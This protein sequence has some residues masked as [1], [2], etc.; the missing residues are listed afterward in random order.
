MDLIHLRY[1]HSVFLKVRQALLDQQA[2]LALLDRQDP[3]GMTVMMVLLDRQ[4][5]LV[6]KDL[7]AMMV[8]TAALV[9]LEQPQVLEHRQSLV[10][11]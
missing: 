6:L 7:R 9:R 11:L 5:L 8:M 3:Q 4:A 1:L 2:E 10:V